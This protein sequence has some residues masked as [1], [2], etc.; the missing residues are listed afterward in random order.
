MKSRENPI[1]SASRRRTR[2]NTLWNVP[3]H[4]PLASSPT[5][6]T[7]RWRISRAALLVNVSARIWLGHD[8]LAAS[9]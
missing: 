9:R 3:I 7:T 8:F 4:I 2:A 1:F 5:R 6:S